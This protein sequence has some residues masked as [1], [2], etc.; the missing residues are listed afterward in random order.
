MQ[1]EPLNSYLCGPRCL[2]CCE[3]GAVLYWRSCSL[4]VEAS[5]D[6]AAAISSNLQLLQKGA[7]LSV[8]G[9]LASS[10]DATGR[11]VTK[12]CT[13]QHIMFLGTYVE[14]QNSR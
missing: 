6:V 14:Q 1:Q 5:G 8:Q 9:K 13:Q 10:Q 3:V 4:Q 2:H 12:V 11:S 7:L